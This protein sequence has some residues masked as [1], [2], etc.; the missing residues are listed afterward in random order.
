MQFHR[1]CKILFYYEEIFGMVVKNV[2]YL[3]Y[4]LKPNNLQISY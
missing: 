3:A 1:K 4:I 2:E